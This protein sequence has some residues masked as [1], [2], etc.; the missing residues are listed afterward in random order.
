MQH[1][2]AH[3]KLNSVAL[4]HKLQRMRHCYTLIC[5]VLLARGKPGFPSTEI[6]SVILYRFTCSFFSLVTLDA[7]SVFFYC[8][9]ISFYFILY[10]MIHAIGSSF[11][12]TV[13]AAWVDYN[14]IKIECV[15]SLLRL[16]IVI[17]SV[18]KW[19]LIMDYRLVQ[20]FFPPFVRERALTCTYTLRVHSQTYILCRICCPNW[21]EVIFVI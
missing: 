6:W 9:V 4:I 15:I 12:L 14:V 13:N 5:Y 7:V 17:C 21:L 10:Y 3:Q 1:S 16:Y 8:M 11:V 20:W 18:F 19:T 2:T